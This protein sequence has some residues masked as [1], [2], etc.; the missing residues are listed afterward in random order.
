MSS[1]RETLHFSDINESS[2]TMASSSRSRGGVHISVPM[3]FVLTLLAVLL[4]VGVGIIV[5]FAGPNRQIVC[6]CEYPKENGGTAGS[7]DAQWEACKQMAIDKGEALP[8]HSTA[9]PGTQ[10]TAATTGKPKVTDIRLPDTLV[11]VHYDLELTPDIYGTDPKTFRFQGKV[12]I[13]MTCKKPTDVV[14]LHINKLDIVDNSIKFVSESGGAAPGYKSWSH[15]KDRQFFVGQLDGAMTAGQN[16]SIEM[17]FSGP[18]TNDLAGLYRS[19]YKRGNGSVTIATTQ[20]QPT[21]ARKAF[22]CFDEPALKAQFTTTLVRKPPYVSLSNMPIVRNETRPNGWVADVYEVTPVMSTYLLAFV[23]CD[24]QYKENTTLRGTKFRVW[25]RPAAIDQVD[26]AL[27]IGGRILEYFEDYFNIPFPLPKTDMIAIPDFA[28]GAMENWGLI[29]YRETALLYDP[30]VSSSSNKQR[31]AVVVAHELAHQWFGNLVTPDWWDDLWLN[32]GFASYVEYLGVDVVEP[33]MRMMD[34]FLLE[35]LQ[36]VM[37]TDSLGSSHPIYVPVQH[38]DEINEIFDRISYAKGASVIRMMNFFLGE[39]TFK[40]GVTNYL[41]ANKYANAFHLELFDSLTQAALADNVNVN[42]TKVMNTWILQ[43]GF[44]VITV[45]RDYVTGTA[46]ATQKHFLVDPSQPPDGKYP[47]P[48]NYKWEVPFTM[49]TNTTAP[50]WQ[51]TFSD[52]IWMPQTDKSLTSANGVPAAANDW[53]V[54]NVMEYGFYRVNY[55]KENWNLI[56]QQLQADLTAIHVRNRAQI[57]DDSFNLARAGTI[58]I[59]DALTLS[60]YMTDERELLPWDAYSGNLGY[61]DSMLEKTAVYGDFQGYMVQQV[62][63]L[64]NSLGWNMPASD[65]HITKRLRYLAIARACKYGHG[66]CLT[67][68]SKQF[69]EYKKTPATNNIAVDLKTVVYCYG[70]KMGGVAEWDFAYNLYKD[71]NVATEKAKLLSALSCS[72]EPWI[73]NRYLN[74]SLDE[75]EIRKQD[76]VTVINYVA[77]NTIGE[78]LAWDFIRARWDM[79]MDRFGGGS[80]LLP[81]LTS[82]VTASFSTVFQKRQLHEFKIAHPDLGSGTRAFE[83]AIE[84][85][86]ANY[87]WVAANEKKI[88]DW[89][90]NALKP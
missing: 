45:T 49:T 40:K 22:P 19:E 52:V 29:T 11:P 74:R 33:D 58:D 66:P 27:S 15:D 46:Q 32:E 24:F 14:K 89:L 3:G 37:G 28:A 25:A 21:D 84:K 85:T 77:R 18:L 60:Q 61:I 10:T 50:K 82:S 78:P 73:L 1:S 63:P 67:E 44:P 68:A 20:F 53:I 90:A 42:V 30:M 36:D 62:I 9:A 72:K 43:M 16:Y 5:H 48:Y 83:Q 88:G 65:P 34:Q 81:D 31:V 17:E 87:K 75:N 86:T 76:A 6:S 56:A 54:G 59:T 69:E 2:T 7:A 70:I 79:I 23:I 39:S 64:Y 12:K 51:Q 38:P 41:N 57:V 13:I 55:D 71:S 8:C 80:F 26:Y 47:S 4:A 35:D